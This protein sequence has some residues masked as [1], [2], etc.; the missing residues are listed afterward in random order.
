MLLTYKCWPLASLTTDS[1]WSKLFNCHNGVRAA[2]LALIGVKAN[3]AAKVRALAV[4]LILFFR[5]FMGVSIKLK[6]CL[7]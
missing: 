4:L 7:P 3:A 6:G 1:G 5:F 2:A